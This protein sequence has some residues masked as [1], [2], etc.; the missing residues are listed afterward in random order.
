MR[1]L[2]HEKYLQ[3]S[4]R[5][6]LDAAPS[7]GG[8]LARIHRPKA[9]A[10]ERNTLSNKGLRRP[11]AGRH[12]QDSGLS[13]TMGGE[14]GN[15]GACFAQTTGDR[16]TCIHPFPKLAT[17]PAF[18]R[19]TSDCGQRR[20]GQRI[21]PPDRSRA[22]R[23]LVVR[24]G[25]RRVAQVSALRCRRTVVPRYGPGTLTIHQQSCRDHCDQ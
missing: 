19:R 4:C 1:K 8:L 23:D 7:R 22:V 11:K 2:F 18:A 13:G 15:G 3:Y 25:A 16:S 21:S 6:S 9:P 10:K 5:T 14:D 20:W 17:Q 12:L 24:G